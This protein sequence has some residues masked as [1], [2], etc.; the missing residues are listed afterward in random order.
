M[1]AFLP[2]PSDGVM[3]KLKIGFFRQISG[4]WLFAVRRVGEKM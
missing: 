3:A 4:T 2:L 1:K